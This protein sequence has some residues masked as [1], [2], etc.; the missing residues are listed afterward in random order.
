MGVDS[1]V[2]DVRDVKDIEG[3]YDNKE[4]SEETSEDI[5]IDRSRIFSLSV[6]ENSSVGDVVL[7]VVMHVNSNDPNIG[8]KKCDTSPNCKISVK[9][10]SSLD[11]LVFVPQYQ[12]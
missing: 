10:A 9:N 2:N 3:E 5:H 1:Q 11:S 8:N 4:G 6:F 7:L 12:P